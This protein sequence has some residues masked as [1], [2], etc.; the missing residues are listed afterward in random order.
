MDQ[1]KIV[2]TEITDKVLLH[3]NVKRKFP[4]IYKK[5]LGLIKEGEF[6]TS[7]GIAEAQRVHKILSTSGAR[8]KIEKV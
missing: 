2:I 3:L 8:V 6:V 1:F 4:F 5:R 7:Y